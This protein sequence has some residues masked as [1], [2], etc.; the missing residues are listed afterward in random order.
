MLE[1]QEYLQT[2]VSHLKMLSIS[3]F[4]ANI[5]QAEKTIF[6]NP[7]LESNHIH[8]CYGKM[9]IREAQHIF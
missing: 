8:D 1:L 6:Q 9:G 5:N 4:L 3:N 7:M 2:L